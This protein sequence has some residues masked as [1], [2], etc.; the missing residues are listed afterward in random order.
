MASGTVEKPNKVF[1]F[2]IAGNKSWSLPAVQGQLIFVSRSSV[3][4]IGFITVDMIN[5]IT[6]YGTNNFM[7]S[8]TATI[9]ND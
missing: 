8:I 2:G 4:I 9:S 5:E 7:T 3:N 6:Y 1:S